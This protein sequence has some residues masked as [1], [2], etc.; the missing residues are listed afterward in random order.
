[1]FHGQVWLSSTFKEHAESIFNQLPKNQRVDFVTNTY[2][3]PNS[4]K[5]A[6]C[7]RRGFSQEVL[8]TGYADKDTL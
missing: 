4:I 2:L 1:M 3:I 7:A 6:E 8:I 5:D